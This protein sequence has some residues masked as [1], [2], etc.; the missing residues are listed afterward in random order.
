MCE[1]LF[2]NSI[3]FYR[4]GNEYI[5]EYNF[6]TD[7]TLSTSFKTNKIYQP[8]KLGISNYKD[9]MDK[10][11]PFIYYLAS[12]YQNVRNW[13]H[14]YEIK[15]DV[16]IAFPEEE[17]TPILCDYKLSTFLNDTSLDITEQE[18]DDYTEEGIE[19]LV[20]VPF[21]IIIDVYAEYTTRIS[22]DSSS[23][24][25]EIIE[26]EEPVKTTKSFKTEQ[27]VICLTN[28]PNILFYDCMHICTCLECEEFKPLNSCP[29]CRAIAI[30]K[31]C[32]LKKKIII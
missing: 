28:Q 25:E 31:N 16:V 10:V 6:G 26:D 19:K 13:D 22:T 20:S 14:K 17:Y 18:L 27:C 21:H 9:L 32:I 23:N 5:T 4:T 1:K 11:N 15:F 24:D 30:E 8:I 2:K 7:A 12:E 29:Y 3:P